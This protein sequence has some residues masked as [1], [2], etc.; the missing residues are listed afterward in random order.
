MA[1]NSPKNRDYFI[2]ANQEA[3]CYEELDEI[4]HTLNYKLYAWIIHDK[5]KLIEKDSETGEVLSE[6]P[7]AT[8]KHLVIELKNPL[9]FNSIQ[10]KFKGAHIEV[11]KYKKSAYQ[12]LI[13]N[14][15]NAKEK[16]QYSLD[17][18]HTNSK[19]EVKQIIETET[20]ELFV[21][22]LFLRYMAE[23]VTNT[24]LFVKRFGLNAYKQYWKPYSDM[25]EVLK[26]GENETMNEDF[27]K[28]LEALDEMEELPF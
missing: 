6:K 9:S 19:L 15:P 12:Y 26:S 28:E 13:H 22:T 3:E 2:T 20:N 16:Y 18:I 1:S 17:E 23:G 27:K 24:Y 5:D 4:V 21:E 8:H 25:L 14:R 7:K 11:P 10:N